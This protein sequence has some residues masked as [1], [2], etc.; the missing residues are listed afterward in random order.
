MSSG[1][2]I[3]ALEKEWE[4][5]CHDRENLRKIFPTGENKVVLP[6]KLD[7]MIWNAQKVFRLN[8]RA[9]TD[10]S[11]L[12]VIQGVN[13]LVKKCT[14]VHGEDS[15]SIQAN[16][17]AT[18]LFRCLIRSTLC[19]RRMA[20]EFRLSAEAFEWLLGE[21]ETRFIQAMVSIKNIHDFLLE[22]KNH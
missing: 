20:D 7:R 15:L 9:Q 22:K 11:P 19:T 4:Q 14:I 13:E 16:D 17:N 18:L 12:R 8:S 2:I 5:L 6:C 1:E 10:L 3:G 21:I